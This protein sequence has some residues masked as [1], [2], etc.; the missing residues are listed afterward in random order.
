[1]DHY[2][3][4]LSDG[5][6]KSDFLSSHLISNYHRPHFKFP[7]YRTILF[8]FPEFGHLFLCR[9]AATNPPNAL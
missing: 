7:F 3:H 4:P 6:L 2:F 8:I 1:M 9:L 5:M